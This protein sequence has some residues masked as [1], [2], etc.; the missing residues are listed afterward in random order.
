MLDHIKMTMRGPQSKS[1]SK[2]RCDI[3]EVLVVAQSRLLTQLLY[4][5]AERPPFTIDELLAQET[6]KQLENLRFRV[7][8][9]DGPGVTA[10]RY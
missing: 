3:R 9:L 4:A 10:W 8:K 5:G 6:A 1:L 2:S 7:D